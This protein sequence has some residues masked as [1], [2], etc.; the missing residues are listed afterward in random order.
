[1]NILFCINTMA[2]GGAERVVS[3]LSSYLVKNNNVAILTLFGEKSEYKLNN[4]VKLKTIGEFKNIPGKLNRFVLKIKRYIEVVK[5]YKPDIIISFLPTSTTYSLIVG[6][7]FNI[8]T[9]VSI[10]NDP[11]QIY[12]NRLKKIVMNITFK[13]ASGFV[14]QT[15]EAKKYFDKKIQKKS[16]I[17]S[18]PI[19]EEFIVK[20][21]NG[22]REKII[23]N[24]GRLEKQKNQR[25]L[26]TAFSKLDKKYNDYKLYI[27]GE[28]S[29]KEDL[30][31]LI[32]ELNLEY[33]V[34]LVGKTENLKDNIYKASLFVLSSD[35]E[36]MPNALME[37]MAL[38]IPC[39]STDCPCGGPKFLIDDGCNGYLVPVGDSEQLKLK[40]EELLSDSE[41]QK[42][43]SESA[44]KICSRL[45]PE[46][47]NEKWEKYILNIKGVLKINN[48]SDN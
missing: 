43:F 12:D 45:N 30:K 15:E 21:Y 6:K 41:K 36:G 34:F 2:K 3:N 47:I 23:V 7:L 22:V 5:E 20:P 18:N 24:V 48:E 35:F 38:G 11:K 29:L 14:F 33:K 42:I 19:N 28:G 31:E 39:I 17:I 44:N 8:P 46:K 9:I 25:L 13:L 37:A 10:R 40:M 27:Y 26:I 32:R 4:S 1:M 16:I